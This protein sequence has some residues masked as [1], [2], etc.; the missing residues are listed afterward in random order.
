MPAICI[1]TAHGFAA[2]QPFNDRNGF[3]MQ[4]RQGPKPLCRKKALLSFN[5]KYVSYRLQF[6]ASR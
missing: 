4:T 6:R 1:R 2:G 5:S 3:E